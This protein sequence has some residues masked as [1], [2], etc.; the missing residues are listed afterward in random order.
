MSTFF[1]MGRLTA[2]ADRFAFN[3]EIREALYRHLSAQMSNGIPVDQALENFCARLQRRNKPSSQKIVRGVARRMRDGST[4][5]SA[6]T[7]WVTPEEAGL[8]ASGEMSASLPRSFDL[9]IESQ[10]RIIRVKR[11]F[12]GAIR[13]PIILG[14]AVYA[15]LWAL[16]AYMTPAFQ[17]IMPAENA[18]GL[19]SLLYIMGD[20][21]R[22]FQMLLVPAVLIL[23]IGCIKWSLPRWRGR[24]RIVAERYFPFSFYRDMEGYTWLM[25]FSALLRAGMT[26]VDILK[27][28]TK[29]ANP[30]LTER[31][32]AMR[33]RMLNGLSLHEA[34]LRKDKSHPKPF[35]FPNPDIVDDISSLSGF[36]DFPER[37]GIIAAQWAEE[38][39]RK[40]S[41]SAEKAGFWMEM[42]MYAIVTLLALSI[43]AISI[44]FSNVPGL[45]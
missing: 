20:L 25:S 33:R 34:L 16:G 37:I 3:W 41:Q 29:T 1:L 5:S 39:E 35:G 26:D 43:N 19:S 30:W 36:P 10:Q 24:N 6:L 31:L 12:K 15:A 14:V 27:F 21:A 28:Q 44:Q 40:T 4:L 45:N 9:I 22:G 23:L 13:R 32:I 7:P 2:W 11:S 42:V 8:I 38:L 18:K 17:L